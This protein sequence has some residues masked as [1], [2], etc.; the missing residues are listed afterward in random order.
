M[1]VL[2][3]ALTSGLAAASS[4][5]SQPPSVPSPVQVRTSL[6]RT[7]MWI[8]DRVTYTVELQ[9]SS[10]VDVLLDDLAADRLQIEGGEAIRVDTED[11]AGAGDIRRVRFVITTF[12]VDTPEVRIAPFT[13]RYFARGTLSAAGQ[14]APAGEVTVPQAVIAIR[15]TLPEGG[16]LPELREPSALRPAPR[17]VRVAGAVGLA[18]IALAVV[19]FA[20]VSADLPR[21]VRRSVAVGRAGWNRRR[22]RQGIEDLRALNPSTP[23]ERISAYA[24]LSQAI[25][26]HLRLTTGI[27]AHAMT[28]AEVR[29]ALERRG[30]GA[31]A[32]EA[33]SLLAACERSQYSPAPLTPDGWRDAMRQADEIVRRKRWR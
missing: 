8:G 27:P 33:E 22:Q 30:S 16:R 3:F 1:K 21:L 31:L 7:A 26:E 18:L 19:P 14:T 2:I 11:G 25:R 17:Y 12:R 32:A 23:D 28:P 24:Q 20:L 6:D 15:S 10:G 4:L 9:S 13:V 5:A 29:E